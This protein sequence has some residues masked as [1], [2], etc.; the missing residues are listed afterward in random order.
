[1][2]EVIAVVLMIGILGTIAIP[3]WFNFLNRQRVNKVNDV[4][5]AAIQEAQKEAKQ[6]KI[7]YSVSFKMDNQV[8]KLAIHPDST[9]A[10]SPNIQWKSMQESLGIKSGQISL[11]T[12]LNVSSG[13]NISNPT[14]N[15]SATYLNSPQTITF[16]YMGT[17]PNFVT[18]A[19]G[20]APGLKIVVAAS[21]NSTKRCVIVKTILGS[22]LRGKNNECN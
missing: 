10:S 11:F 20:E 7:S 1:M 16:D 8:P 19:T 15:T 14:V 12:N 3:S 18:P 6:K 5:F 22:T 21:N 13:K 17:L 4:V 9:A 2:V